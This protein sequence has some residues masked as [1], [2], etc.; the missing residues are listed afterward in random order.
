MPRPIGQPVSNI[1]MKTML[2]NMFVHMSGNTKFPFT[3]PLEWLGIGINNQNWTF[4]V[5]NSIL[6]IGGLSCAYHL[7]KQLGVLKNNIT[8]WIK[9]FWNAKKYL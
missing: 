5:P 1:S 3:V 8:T 4:N 2:N 6:W 9:S 7:L